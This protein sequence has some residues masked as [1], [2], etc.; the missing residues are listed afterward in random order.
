MR[1]RRKLR[2]SLGRCVKCGSHKAKKGL[3]DCAKCLKYQKEYDARRN[4]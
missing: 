2:R 3:V 4:K 1:E